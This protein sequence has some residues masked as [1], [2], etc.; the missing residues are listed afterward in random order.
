MALGGIGSNKSY[1][2]KKACKMMQKWLSDCDL[3]FP[4]PGFR[5]EH[6]FQAIV[7]F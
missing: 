3:E 1:Y 6:Q 4:K 2:M 5:L 7:L